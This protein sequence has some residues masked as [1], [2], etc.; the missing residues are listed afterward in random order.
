MN[1]NEFQ[2]IYKSKCEQQAISNG[3]AFLIKTKTVQY[4]NWNGRTISFCF[5]LNLL[6]HFKYMCAI[7]GPA[8]QPF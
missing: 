4:S 8:N 3:I 7:N 2:W 5:V 1:L 6:F